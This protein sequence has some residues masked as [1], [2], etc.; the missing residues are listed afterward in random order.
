LTTR[1]N[2]FGGRFDRGV[3]I[4]PDAAFAVDV[5]MGYTPDDRPERCGVM[6]DGPMVA[7]H[8]F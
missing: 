4:A 8:R 3:F 7:Y 5:S 6:G 2:R 1:E